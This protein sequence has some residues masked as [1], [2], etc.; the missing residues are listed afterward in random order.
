VITAG[1][2]CGSKNTKT[3]IL[4]DGNII[5]KALA[6]TGFDQAASVRESLTWALR[7]AGISRDDVERMAGAGA[8]SKAIED[9]DLTINDIKAMAVAALYFFP[10]V[11][12]VVDV[13]AEG[14]RVA[15]LDDHGKVEDFALN[16][17]CAAGAGAFIE[18]MARALET[19]IEQMGPLALS[20]QRNI[21]MNAQC[22]IFAESEVVGLIHSKTEKR[23]ISR[24]IHDAMAGRVASM[25]RRVGAHPG[26]CLLGGVAQNPGFVAPLKEELNVDRLLIPD[27]PQ[28]AAALGA[29]LEAAKAGA[30]P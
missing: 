23:D 12:T 2:D 5:G 4:R 1:V 6:P 9:A 8:G 17:K 11:R 7:E 10:D 25:I 14:A 27:I 28:Y 24:A 3:I 29:G 18:A 22:V 21:A 20:S 13:G 30:R 19:P 15:K 16:E 26:I